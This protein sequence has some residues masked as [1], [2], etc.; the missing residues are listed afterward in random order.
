MAAI[1]VNLP[2]VREYRF[3]LKSGRYVAVWARDYTEATL[4][5]KHDYDEPF[6]NARRQEAG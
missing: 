4:V 1:I 3:R 6:R 5:M 2:T